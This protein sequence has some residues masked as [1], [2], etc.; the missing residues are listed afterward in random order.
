MIQVDYENVRVTGAFFQLKVTKKV[1]FLW[2][3]GPEPP[4]TEKFSSLPS[5][6]R[7]SIFVVTIS[8][9]ILILKTLLFFIHLFILITVQLEK[10]REKN[11]I[12]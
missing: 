2:N 5:L 12:F 8:V 7:E 9:G 3:L 1:S 10:E 11:N 4:C 6:V